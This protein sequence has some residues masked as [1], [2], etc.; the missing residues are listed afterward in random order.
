[1]KKLDD[2]SYTY[3]SLSVPGG[4]FVTGFVFHPNKKDILYARTD[5]G[6]IY[7]FDFDKNIWHSLADSITEFSHHLALPLSIAVDEEK[8]DMLYAMCG[9]SRKNSPYG[10]SSLL[11]S[12]NCGKSFVE[13]EVPFCCHGNAPARSSAER[14]AYKNGCLFFGT[15]GEGLMRS[16]D[17]GDSWTK[18][19]LPEENTVFV[20]FPHGHEIMLVS[21]TGESCSYGTNRG[22]TLY[23]S[24][25]MGESFEKLP[26]PESIDDSRCFHNGFVPYSAACDKDDIYISFT[27]LYY[28]SMHII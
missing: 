11:I 7:R 8:P 3:R 9:N 28:L 14:L 15:Q 12:D 20:F 1:M 13:K 25:D 24:Y 16:S 21:C 27:P 2:V 19:D 4:G 22:H 5:I 18:L 6:G 10:R 26:I 17:S 23:A